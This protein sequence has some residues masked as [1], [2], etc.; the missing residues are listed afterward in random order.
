MKKCVFM[1]VLLLQNT[2]I[3]TAEFNEKLSYTQASSLDFV[4]DIFK[5]MYKHAHHLDSCRYLASPKCGG[6]KF[7]RERQ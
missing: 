3:L 6:Y 4:Y 1:C 2:R 5:E 7:M